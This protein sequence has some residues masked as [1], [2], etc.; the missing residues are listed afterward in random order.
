MSYTITI[1]PYDRDLNKA[2]MN[3]VYDYEENVLRGRRY[4]KFTKYLKQKKKRYNFWVSST[5]TDTL[6]FDSQKD[7]V[8]FMLK[9]G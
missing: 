2:W 3:T 6:I 4:P 1:S 5:Y 9:W 7:F 8:Y